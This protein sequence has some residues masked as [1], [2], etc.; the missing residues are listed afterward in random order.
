MKKLLEDYP[1]VIEQPLAWGDMDALKHVNNIV[2]FRYLE[3]SR[4]AYFEKINEMELIDE[5][6]T[7]PILASIQCKFKIPLTYPDNIYIGAKITELSEDRFVMKHCIVS[8]RHKAIAAIGE[9]TV[10]WL[11]YREHKKSPIPQALKERIR[12][13]ELGAG[14]HLS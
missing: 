4:I 11:N 3:N 13:L 9:G 1:V 5:A 12:T 8:Q 2:Y 7:G 6:G 10:V 14:N